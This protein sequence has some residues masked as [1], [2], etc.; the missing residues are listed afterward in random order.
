MPITTY[1]ANDLSK[2]FTDK[3][4]SA[5]V[6]AHFITE[7]V[8]GQSADE[9]GV[10][11]FVRHHL[12]IDPENED[13]IK[14]AV[15]RILGKEVALEERKKNEDD[16]IHELPEEKL[17]YGVTVIRKDAF[18][19]WLGDWMIKACIKCA[20]TRTKVT[21]R[22]SGIKGAI[23]EMGR[24]SAID[25][26]L[27]PGEDYTTQHVH[28]IDPVTDGP[29]KTHFVQFKGRPNTGAKPVSIVSDKE[30]VPVGTQFA[31]EF[32]WEA[33]ML[34]AE[35]MVYMFAACQ[36]IGLGSCKAFERGKFVVDSLELDITP[37]RVVADDKDAA[38]DKTKDKTKGRVK[39]TV[40]PTAIETA[41]VVLAG[42]DGTE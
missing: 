8:G 29:A 11:A 31:F 20:A 18:G 38:K 33:G 40:A 14:N 3:T 21:T 26:S 4:D 13:E 15:D 42:E 30:C 22:K 35:D 37:A 36:N 34:T 1:N 24:V 19:P 27:V 17:S 28:L 32:R 12:K 9:A 41:A 5:R 25:Q 10:E 2:V 6:H 39:K 7:C 23:I 16:P